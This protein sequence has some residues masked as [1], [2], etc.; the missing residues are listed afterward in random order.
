LPSSSACGPDHADALVFAIGE[1]LLHERAAILEFYR[2]QAEDRISGADGV[3]SRERIAA[4]SAPP[5]PTHD[6]RAAAP[7][8]RLQ[9]PRPISGV[10]GS[11]GTYYMADGAHVVLVNAAEAPVGLDRF[12]GRRSWV[13]SSKAP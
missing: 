10:H 8:V 13:G 1:L 4:Q 3:P 2:R 9:S 6:E 5:S 12:R 11:F 7:K